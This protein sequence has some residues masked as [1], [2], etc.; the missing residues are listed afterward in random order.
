MGFHFETPDRRQQLVF[1]DPDVERV[2]A[3][4]VEADYR[5]D[6]EV[7]RTYTGADRTRQR[8]PTKT[9]LRKALKTSEGCWIRPEEA[10][11][12]GESLKSWAARPKEGVNGKESEPALPEE[13]RK[14]LQE[15]QDEDL[16]LIRKF[17]DFVQASATRG[18]FYVY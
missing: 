16:K 8:K 1:S 11:K 3:V 13:K 5:V 14:I 17:Q 15:L 10:R 7:D 6:Q 2:L 9:S 12:V 18:G 4:L